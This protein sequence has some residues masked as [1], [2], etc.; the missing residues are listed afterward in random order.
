MENGI[1]NIHGVDC[2]EKDGTAYLSLE[3][4]AWGLGFTQTQTKN[5]KEYASVRWERVEQ[6]LAEIGFPHLWGKRNLLFFE[7]VPNAS[8]K[9]FVV[10]PAFY[11]FLSNGQFCPLA[12]YGKAQ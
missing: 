11:S 12:L 8:R 2:Y 3:A 7:R 1:L 10:F 4:V 5:G 9:T 6:Y